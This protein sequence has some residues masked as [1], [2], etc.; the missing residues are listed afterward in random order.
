MFNV[1]I[2][3]QLRIRISLVSLFLSF[4]VLGLLLVQFLR[5]SLCFAVVSAIIRGYY[6][7]VL[8]W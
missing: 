3:R 5:D 2:V 1:F 6:T 7:S 8:V 4:L